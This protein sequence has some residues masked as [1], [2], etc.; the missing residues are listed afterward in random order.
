ML[1]DSVVRALDSPIRSEGPQF[2]TP[3]KNKKAP[4]PADS[5]FEPNLYTWDPRKKCHVTP[6]S[7]SFF[8]MGLARRCAR[9][10]RVRNREFNQDFL[11]WEMEQFDQWVANR[12][13]KKFDL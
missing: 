5:P 4:E 12:P 1:S 8:G 11:D 13:P 7:R 2:E 3:P 10:E 6:D 9:C